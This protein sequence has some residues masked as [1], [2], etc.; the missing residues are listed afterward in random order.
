MN[1]INVCFGNQVKQIRL[2]KGL[3]QDS[4]AVMSGLERSQLSKIESGQVDVQI[5]T[6]QKLSTALNVEIG[7][8]MQTRDLSMHPFV[9]WAGGKT[10]LLDRLIALMPKDYK[11]Y[12]EPFIGGGALFFKVKPR[13]PHIND[14]NDELLSAYRCFLKKDTCE[15]LMAKLDEYDR[16]HSEE[17][18]LIVRA[19]DKDQN[20]QANADD[21]ERAARMIYLN[22]A[23]FNGLFRVNSKGFFN[24]PSGKKKTVNAYDKVNFIN[25]L[26][27]FSISKPVIT[28]EDFSKAVKN[29]K[30][31][32]FVYFDPPYD[33]WDDKS[34]FTS[35]D[36]EG[37]GKKDQARL[38]DCF[39]E[40]DKKGVKAMLSNHN[41]KYINELYSGFEINV[42][43]AKRMINSVA[44]GR[45]DVEE[46]II[47]NFK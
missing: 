21:V 30:S 38:A 39:R 9:K 5:S 17:N 47:R 7:E 18:Y 26:G 15:R 13:H 29:A 36:K 3:T 46:V 33:T 14:M 8:L 4:L 35:Y 28:H 45:G 22:K 10:Q 27:Y 40:L 41:T 2:E 42:V 44:S 24:V 1:E 32:D 16:N 20:W 11:D 23:C 12:Y 34:S 31:G 19:L 25:V 43:N 37:F 6:V